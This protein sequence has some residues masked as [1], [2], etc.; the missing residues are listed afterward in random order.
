MRFTTCDPKR[1]IPYHLCYLRRMA[2]YSGGTAHPDKGSSKPGAKT[3]P[4]IPVLEVPPD[5]KLSPGELVSDLGDFILYNGHHR[6][7]AALCAGA[8]EVGIAILETDEDLLMHGRSE[9]LSLSPPSSSIVDH[10]N[11]V[12]EMVLAGTPAAL[13]AERF[14]PDKPPLFRNR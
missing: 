14:V 12:Y 3:M 5:L 6:R 9:M 4:A 7:M 8:N 11:R 10:R 1:L 13:R 2:P